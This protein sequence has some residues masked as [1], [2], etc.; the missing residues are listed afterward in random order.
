MSVE[1]NFYAN[2]QQTAI[3]IGYENQEFIADKVLPRV[4]TGLTQKYSWRRYRLNEMFS[5]PDTTIGR[6]SDANEVEFGYDEFESSTKDRGLQDPIPNSDIEKA[7]GSNSPSPANMATEMLTE[8]VLLDRE[9]RVANL[10]QDTTIYLSNQKLTLSGTSQ[11]SDPASDPIKTIMT[12]LDIP[13]RRPNVMVL[14]QEVYTTLAM[15]PKLVNAYTGNSG[16]SGVVPPDFLAKL[17]RLEEVL[18]GA[19]WYNSS[20]R[21]QNPTLTRLWGKQISLIRR[22]NVQLPYT[23][24]FGITAQ[25]GTR[26]GMQYDDPKIGLKGGKRIKVGEQ[27]EEKICGPEFGY[28]IANAIA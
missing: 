11:F 24:T 26:V 2:V 12:A 3:A 6:T 18:I 1:S 5:I 20:K 22:Q 19:A 8:L 16:G 21:G 17:F 9:R 4:P 7:E 10:V 28:C 15:H 27:V 25:T 23:M 13:V 14:N